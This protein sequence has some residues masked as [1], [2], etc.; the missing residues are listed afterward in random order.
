MSSIIYLIRHAESEHNISKDFTQRDPP[1]TATGLAQASAL[2]ETFPDTA[3]IAVVL[4]SPL[5]RTLQTTTTAFP[6]VFSKDAGA[7]AQLI[8]DPDLQERSDLSCDTGSRRVTLDKAFPG[9]DF[10]GLEDEWF[11]K[12]GLY[13]ADDIAVAQRAQRFRDKLRDIITSLKTDRGEVDEGRRRNVVVVTHGVFMKFL[14]E[15]RAIDL[16]KAGW[17][18]FRIGSGKDGGAVLVPL[19]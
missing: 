3:S 6:Q 9:L 2:I 11:V 15:D 10:G 18:A 4:T 5:T 1:L 16:P 12:E 19:E 8:I 7:G 14:A 13:A 17:K